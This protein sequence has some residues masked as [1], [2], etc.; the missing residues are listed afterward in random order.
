MSTMSVTWYVAKCD[1]CGRTYGDADYE[2]DDESG[3][4][5][6][7]RGEAQKVA[8]DDGWR[9]YGA[10]YQPYL[11]SCPECSKCDVCERS[12]AH[13][14]GGRTRCEDHPHHDAEGQLHLTIDAGTF[15]GGR[16]GATATFTPAVP[17]D[18]FIEWAGPV[19]IPTPHD[20]LWYL[21]MGD[22]GYVVQCRCKRRFTGDDENA[23]REEHAAHVNQHAN[24]HH[25]PAA[26]GA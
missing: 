18:R 8:I 14:H 22:V 4:E 23:A 13:H 9:L 19:H 15:D 26:D 10:H 3:A 17:D 21:D 7:T 25:G 12:P 1:T 5:R 24:P 16:V 6:A 2:L 11:L 20:I